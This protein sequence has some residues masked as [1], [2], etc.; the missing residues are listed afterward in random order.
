MTSKGEFPK[1]LK[2]FCREIGVPA[3]L[4]CDPSGEQSSGE[5][6]RFAN[7]VGMNLKLLE[8]H[9][10]HANLAELYVGIMKTAISRDLRESECPLSFWCC[11]AEWRMRVCNAT[12]SKLFQLQGSNPNTATFGETSDISDI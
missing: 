11:A 8:A 4:I 1:A 10:Q 3:D 5:V 9:T 6:R 12:A 7:K 2:Q